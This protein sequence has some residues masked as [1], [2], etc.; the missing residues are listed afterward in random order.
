[1]SYDVSL[2]TASAPKC[3]T[4]GHEPEREEHFSANHTS[5]TACM[6]YEAGCDIASFDGRCAKDLA[7]SLRPAIDAMEA[8]PGKYEPMEPENGWGS[9]ESTLRFMRKILDACDEHPNATVSVWR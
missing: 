3:P 8:D 7:A 6:W 2:Y 1:M 5:N 9:Y 4:C